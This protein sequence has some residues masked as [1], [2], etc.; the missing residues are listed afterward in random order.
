MA[1]YEKCYFVFNLEVVFLKRI[2]CQ[3]AEGNP[4]DEVHGSSTQL[5]TTA[6]SCATDGC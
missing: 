5:I 2:A 6:A 1:S 3:A 4:E